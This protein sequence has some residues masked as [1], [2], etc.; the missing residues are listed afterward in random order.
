MKRRFL[1]RRLPG[2][3]GFTSATCLAPR[4]N[5]HERNSFRAE[6]VVLWPPADGQP[7]QVHALNPI[8]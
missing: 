8:A 4:L 1:L 7:K 3:D 5:K 6:P 2:N